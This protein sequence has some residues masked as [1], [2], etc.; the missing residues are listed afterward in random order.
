MQVGFVEASVRLRRM[1]THGSAE[2]FGAC[3]AQM[4]ATSFEGLDNLAKS[5]YALCMATKTISIDLKA[6]QRLADA[7]LSPSDS[8]S[9]VIHRAR[10][11]AE[12]KTCG[13]LLAA[14][15]DMPIA[16]E[17]VLD[18]LERAQQADP[19]PDNPWE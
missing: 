14:L 11:D 4:D 16:E 12:G 5:V 17:H 18:D 13:R 3:Q 2:P 1:L 15:K 9:Q 10:W 7:R 8:F 19:A 6:Y